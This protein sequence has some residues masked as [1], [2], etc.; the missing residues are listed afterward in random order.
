MLLH[1]KLINK[2]ISQSLT[3]PLPRYFSDA[4]LF[5]IITKNKQTSQPGPFYRTHRKESLHT[6]LDPT[7]DKTPLKLNIFTSIHPLSLLHILSPEALL[8]ILTPCVFN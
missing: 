4:L 7:K 6:G 2:N 8:K 1:S 3:L 5:L